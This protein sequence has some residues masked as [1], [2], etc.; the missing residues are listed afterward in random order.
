MSA[1]GL[2]LMEVIVVM[3]IIG[4]LLA[5]TWPSL[6]QMMLRAR[7]TEAVTLLMIS[8]QDLARCRALYDS[9]LP[10]DGC[11]WLTQL[12]TYSLGGRYRI[13]PASAHIEVEAFQL[14][15]VPVGAQQ[16]DG[17]CLSFVLDHRGQQSVTGAALA[18]RCWPQ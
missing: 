7:R 18:V 3:A 16:R 8:A 6:D 12:P 4:A 1:R 2:S 14:T 11:P 17:E 9:Y 5:I 10:Q 15:A 13:D